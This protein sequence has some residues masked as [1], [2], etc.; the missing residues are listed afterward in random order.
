MLIAP[1][2][3]APQLGRADELAMARLV[4]SKTK[5]FIICF[6]RSAFIHL[7]L[8]RLL[9]LENLWDMR[10]SSHRLSCFLRPGFLMSRSSRNLT[11]WV[12][13]PCCRLV[14]R[15]CMRSSPM[16]CTLSNHLITTS[17]SNT[18]VE[19]RSRVPISYIW[20]PLPSPRISAICS[21]S[22]VPRVEAACMVKC[23]TLSAATSSR[24]PPCHGALFLVI[25]SASIHAPPR[26]QP[27][28][29]VTA[30]LHRQ[31]LDITAPS[32]RVSW[33]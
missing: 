28:P 20:A 18:P 29:I 31:D 8:S 12:L 2:D 6:T 9:V 17:S 10:F 32:L 21:A 30:K 22:F 16:R 27:P 4:T 7:H 33:S 5:G 26:I 1:T 23:S 24:A 14:L 25:N 13:H 15:Y 11:T 19:S 3:V